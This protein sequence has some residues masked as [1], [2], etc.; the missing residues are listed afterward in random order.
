MSSSS[1]DGRIYSSYS[2]YY[3]SITRELKRTRYDIYV[4]LIIRIKPFRLFLGSITDRDN[5]G[6]ETVSPG[7]DYQR[8]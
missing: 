1:E 6:E 3:E 5:Q 8:S 7:S 2:Y 4:D